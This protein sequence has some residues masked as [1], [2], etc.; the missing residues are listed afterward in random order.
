MSRAAIFKGC[1]RIIQCV[2]SKLLPSVEYET[3]LGITTQK[4]NVKKNVMK[5][6]YTFEFTIP[7]KAFKY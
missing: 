1:S 2:Y 3:K 6:G 4:K 5:K 7:M